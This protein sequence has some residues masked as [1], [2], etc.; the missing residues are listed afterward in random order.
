MELIVR[1]NKGMYC[2]QGD[3]YVDPYRPVK[4]AVITHA[5]SDHA[6]LGSLQYYSS[7]KT[8]PLL[9]SRKVPALIIDDYDYGE[10]F[11][12]NG[13][14]I[15]FHPA[16]HILGSSQVR[17]EY[18][19]HIWLISG[20]YKRELDPTCEPYE[21][22]KCDVFITESTFAIPIYVWPDI[23]ETMEEVHRWWK[24][25][26][27]VGKT[28][29]L[30]GY[31]LGKAQRLIAELRKLTDKEIFSYST[32][33]KLNKDYESLGV[34][35]KNVIDASTEKDIKSLIV[36]PPQMA[37]SEWINK[38]K[39]VSVAFASGW[40]LTS[41]GR[42]QRKFDRGFVVS[43]H[44]DWPSLIKSCE[45]NQPKRVVAHHGSKDVLEKYLQAKGFSTEDLRSQ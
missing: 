30:L 34:S 41:A 37:E 15:S 25:C 23:N 5:H 19:G 27:K 18:E 38:F 33:T 44:C 31:S 17:I 22:V 2:P 29:I 40:M 39:N 20:D 13:V 43:D 4:R 11:Q 24:D 14:N 10:I 35:L 3:F 1:T 12:I 36:A 16:G 21:I 6:T 7:K 9:V 26:E 28:P 32:I 8:K 45:Q 42:K